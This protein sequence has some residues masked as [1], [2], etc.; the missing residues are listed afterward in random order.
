MQDFTPHETTD[1][2]QCQGCHPSVKPGESGQDL[3]RFSSAPH[4]TWF[5]VRSSAM[6][7]TKI[8]RVC[9]RS[10]N[11]LTCPQSA[12]IRIRLGPWRNESRFCWSHVNDRGSCTVAPDLMEAA[13]RCDIVASQY[14]YHLSNEWHGGASSVLGGLLYLSICLLLC[15][16]SFLIP[17]SHQCADKSKQDEPNRREARPPC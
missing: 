13:G 5:L 11:P 15:L 10:F 14:R 8:G 1:I 4:R 2:S 12:G 9:R 6:R 7:L 3:R 17:V 16:N